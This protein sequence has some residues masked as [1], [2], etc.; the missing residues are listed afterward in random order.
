MPTTLLE[1]LPPLKR[2]PNAVE[3][4]GWNFSGTNFQA[5]EE[6]IAVPSSMG[7]GT[8]Q[9]DL[10]TSP[11]PGVFWRL[12]KLDP[13]ANAMDYWVKGD[14][15][16]DVDGILSDIDLCRKSCFCVLHVEIV[17]N[18]PHNK[19]TYRRVCAHRQVRG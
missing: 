18:I 12:K 13:T 8:R 19:R 17:E 9:S 14:D 16:W 11:P 10:P 7:P 4:A 5:R 3:V 15:G 2:L 6:E 1:C